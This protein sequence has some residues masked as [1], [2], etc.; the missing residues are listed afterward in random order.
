MGR[1]VLWHKERLLHIGFEALPPDCQM[2]AC[3]D[4][5]VVFARTDWPAAAA[6]VPG[7]R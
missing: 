2:V 3:L 7:S 6:V 1:D 5:D 4:S